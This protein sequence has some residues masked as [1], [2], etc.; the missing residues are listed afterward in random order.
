M[1]KAARRGFQAGFARRRLARGMRS[2][3]A[4]H[5]TASWGGDLSEFSGQSEAAGGPV[6]WLAR[7]AALAVL[8]A[9]IAVAL[10]AATFGDTN[11]HAD[12]LF[13]FLVGQRMHDGLLPYVDVWDRKPFGLFLVYYAIAGVSHSVLAYQ[14]AA[15]LA[16]GLTAW[17]IAAIV[18]EFAAWRGGMFAGLAYLLMLGPF[19]GATGQ[20]PDF[21]NPLIA[22]GTWLILRGRQ[23]LARGEVPGGTWLAMLLGGLAITVK[24]TSVVEAVWLGL[25]ASW[26]LAKSL[27]RPVLL[28]IVLGLALVGAAPALAIAAGYALAGHWG[29]FWH[30]MVTSNVAKGRSSGE[31]HRLLGIALAAAPLLL[32]ALAGLVGSGDRRA[33]GFLAGWTVAALLGFLAVPNF[34]PH[35]LLP[36]LVPLAAASGLL[37]ERSR[38]RLPLLVGLALYS[39][40]WHAPWHRDWALASAKSMDDLAA[41]VRKHDSGGGLLVFDGPAYLYALTGERFLSPLVF[42]HHLNHAIESDVSH[43]RTAMEMDRILAKEPGVVVMAVYASNHPVNAYSRTR[44][45]GYVRRNCRL[46]GVVDLAEGP[47]KAPIAVFGDCRKLGS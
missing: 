21:Y 39:F 16:A 47:L 28:R 33:R 27:P 32:A 7:P 36:A 20:A 44:T 12:E 2:R 43:L 26:L 46:A 40:L 34:Y 9:L 10:Q 17:L 35:Y 38:L 45:L 31:G 37:F 30:A 29:E 25:Y 42:P 11:R 23:R 14:F 22:G 6:P 5:R 13:Y 15:C 8:F 18:R 24:Q 41:L 3:Y 19:E 4:R 1:R